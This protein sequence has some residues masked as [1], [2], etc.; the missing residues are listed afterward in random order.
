[1]RSE[2]IKRRRWTKAELDTVR[3][4]AARQAAGDDSSIDTNEIPRLT[5]E[6]LAQM[7]RLREIR[8]KIPVSVRLD[9]RVLDWLKSKGEGHLTRINDILTNLMEANAGRLNPDDRPRVGPIVNVS[10]GQRR[11]AAITAVSDGLDHSFQRRGVLLH[12]PLSEGPRF[13]HVLLALD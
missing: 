7:V 2:D 1:V 3:R 6:Q 5:D 9:P 4:I 10:G 12:R 8:P 13:D 11:K